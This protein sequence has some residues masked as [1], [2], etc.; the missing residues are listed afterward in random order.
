[1]NLAAHKSSGL[2][3]AL[4][5]KRPHLRT[6]TAI[7]IDVGA[8][9]VKAVQLGRDRFGDGAWRITAAAEMPRDADAQPA[10]PT[11]QGA[12]QPG[13][14]QPAAAQPERPAYALSGAEIGRLL[15]TIERQGFRGSDVVLAMPNDKVVSS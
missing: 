9:S 10:A 1:M 3:G 4:R 14:A 11:P 2:P 13:T 7:G 12:A 5:G 15:G 8:R 6:R